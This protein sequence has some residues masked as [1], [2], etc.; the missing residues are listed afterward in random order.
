MPSPASLRTAVP[1]LIGA[2]LMLSLSMGLRQSLGIFVPPVTRDLGLSIADMTLAVAIQNVAWGVVQPFT[3]ALVARLGFRP[4]ML[5]GALTYILGLLL[6]FWANG[7]LMIMLGAGICIGIALACLA[8]SISMAVASRAVSGA[9]RSLALG[10][11]SAAGSLGAM[12]AAPIGQLLIQGFDWRI[13]ILG[14]AVLAG[15]L[16]P[17]VWLAGKV[18]RLPIAPLAGNGLLGEGQNGGEIIRRALRHGPFLIMAGSYSV[19]GMQLVFLT[20][21]L[22]SYLEICGMDPMLSAQALGLIGGFN[23]LGSLFY[24]WAGGRWNKRALLGKIYILRSLTLAAYFV[25]PATPASTLLFAAIIGFLWF[26]V[27]PL[28]AG[29]ISDMFGLRWQPMLQGVAFLSHQLGSFIGAYGGGLVYDLLGS[30]N[31]AWKTGVTLGLIA[32]IAQLC[33]AWRRQDPPLAAAPA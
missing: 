32:G 14:F 19:C 23:M 9:H 29:A 33:S 27:V 20:T 13:G 7:F 30:Y 25:L 8:S 17:A 16:L 6:M 11:V 24:G 1:I 21:H 26:G 3:G 15:G 10:M 2:S 18:D 12:V 22:P 28:I 5:T 31:V 4:I